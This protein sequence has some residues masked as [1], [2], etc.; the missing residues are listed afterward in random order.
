MQRNCGRVEK[1][2]HDCPKVVRMERRGIVESKYSL[3]KALQSGTRD[4][5]S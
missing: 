5:V 4:L 3:I 2:K 1:T